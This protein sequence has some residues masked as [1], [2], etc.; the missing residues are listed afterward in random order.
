MLINLLIL[1]L[2][3]LD[4]IEKSK[5]QAFNKS[6]AVNVAKYKQFLNETCKVSFHVYLDKDA[7]SL[8]WRDLTG[9]EKLKL[10][11]K[12]DIPK[13]S[14]YSSCHPSTKNM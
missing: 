1:E 10:F 8:K 4:G 9:P 11:N 3:R 6:V 12:I 13:L 5:L 7:K 14:S 2:Q